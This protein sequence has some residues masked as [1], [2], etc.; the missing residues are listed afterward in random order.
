MCRYLW[1]KIKKKKKVDVSVE[2]YKALVITTLILSTKLSN[3]GVNY[4]S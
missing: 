2:S 1:Y 3:F 4:F